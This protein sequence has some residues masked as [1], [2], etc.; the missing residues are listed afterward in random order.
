[1][2]GDGIVEPVRFNAFP[3]LKE[4]FLA[5]YM[6]AT[7]MIV[8]L[9]ISMREQG[10][11]VKIVYLGHRDGTTMMVRKDSSIF[12]LEDLKGKT[13]AIPNRYSNQ[14]LILYRAL[15]KRGMSVR[16]LD[17]RELPPPE[18]PSSLAARAIDGYVIGEP[19]AAQA[20]MDGYGKILFLAKDEWPNFISCALVVHEDAIKNH[21]PEIQRLVD[22]I[23]KSGQWLDQR[24]DHRMQA[25]D[26]VGKHYYHQNP[27][28]L[29]FVLSKPADR[30]KYTNLRLVRRDLDEI[31]KLGVE[32]GIFKGNI[33]F[34]DYADTSFVPE[35]AVIEPYRWEARK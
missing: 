3:E 18:H 33:G 5:G 32:A 15:K 14:H 1:M 17:L 30:V 16:D 24:I 6:P 8:P 11:P 9:A 31:Y 28:L 10:V 25:A 12:R 4:A 19:F 23:A 2:S 13:V 35:N 20:E 22:G 7:F 29:R 26:F 34:E 21:R 27:D